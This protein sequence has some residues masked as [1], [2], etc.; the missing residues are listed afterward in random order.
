LVRSF[1]QVAGT[2]EKHPEVATS[3]KAERS[4]IG[5]TKH[6]ADCISSP[7]RV[8]S[9]SFDLT[10]VNDLH[11]MTWTSSMLHTK[12]RYAAVLFIIAVGSDAYGE[13]ITRPSSLNPGDQYRIAFVTSGGRNAQSANI[14]DYNSFVSTQANLNPTL[15]ALGTSWTAIGSTISIEARDNTNTNPSFIGVPIF[16]LDGSKI[17]NNNADLWDG[18]IE[19][20]LQLDQ[21]GATK[22]GY[23]WTG[24]VNSGQRE[25]SNEL[26]TSTTLLVAR[27]RTDYS[28]YGWVNSFYASPALQLSL[29]GISGVLTVPISVPE[30]TSLLFFGIGMYVM[31]LVRHPSKR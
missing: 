29:Y 23:V 1:L 24:S 17:A 4:G 25:P 21:M 8:R 19:N 27:G 20:F 13:V 31:S 2:P 16:R 12:I 22:I 5:Q 15:A 18:A 10:F 3:T 11:S 14:A 28:G 30:P 7:G 26:G 9:V 6:F